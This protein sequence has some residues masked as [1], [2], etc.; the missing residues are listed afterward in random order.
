[1]ERLKIKEEIFNFLKGQVGNRNGNYNSNLQYNSIEIMASN[2]NTGDPNLKWEYY[3]VLGD[4]FQ[5]GVLT[6]CRGGEFFVITKKGERYLKEDNFDIFDPESYLLNFNG[7]DE[8]TKF[9]LSEAIHSFNKD[10]HLSSIMALG[11]ASESLMLNLAKL[12]FDKIKDVNGTEILNSKYSIFNVIKRINDQC[13][14]KKIENYKEK[15]EIAVMSFSN[16]IREYRND[17]NHPKKSEIS[18]TLAYS[19]LYLFKEQYKKIN[20]LRE[21]IINFSVLDN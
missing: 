18:N 7:I 13:M 21:K 10:L 3:D 8:V 19:L 12:L 17:Y 11:V 5:S 4:F 16:I 15:Y 9:Y 2:K 14:S 1:M 6:N 20:E